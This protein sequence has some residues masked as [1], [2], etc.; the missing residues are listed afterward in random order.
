MKWIPLNCSKIGP[1]S[2]DRLPVFS[3]MFSAPQTG[4]FLHH[5]Y[6]SALLNDLFGIQSRG[7]CA[8]AGQLMVKY[9]CIVW[10]WIELQEAQW[11]IFKRWLRAL[12]F[13][14][15]SFHFMDLGPYAQ[16][17]MGMDFELATRYENVL[18]E[19]QRLDRT[20][21][22]RYREYSQNEILRPGEFAFACLSLY[23][24]VSLWMSSCLCE[25]WKGVTQ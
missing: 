5:N 4:L 7:G 6:A 12:L 3:L 19:D 1:T 9:V 10:W 8:C 25:L 24:C 18:L 20:H 13:V 22:R 23:R 2:S 16:K 17:L 14:F 21:L 11:A 15:L